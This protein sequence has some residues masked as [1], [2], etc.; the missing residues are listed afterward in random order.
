VINILNL[1][2]PK[3]D[4]CLICNEEKEIGSLCTDCYDKFEFING[5]RDVDIP[6]S[7]PLVYNNFLRK[8]FHQYKFNGRNYYYKIF[9]EILVNSFKDS[10]N[11]V[12]TIVA[13][14]MSGREKAKR[15]FDQIEI[16]VKEVA[17][18]FDVFFLEGALKK[19]KETKRQTG[20][21]YKERSENLKGCFELSKDISARKILLIDDIITTG[22]TINEAYRAL[23]VGQPISI[24]GLTI[25][26]A[27]I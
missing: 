14:P 15:G 12:D 4:F 9:V 10:S 25:T 17:K 13:I 22:A 11:D 23:S 3:R 5:K 2:F 26:S 27:R 21:D 16:L 8:V 6:V 7:F 24:Q 19:V 18:S 20:L 1:L